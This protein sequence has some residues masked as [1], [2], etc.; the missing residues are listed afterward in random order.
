QAIP[1]AFAE[2]WVQTKST[3]NLVYHMLAGHVSAK[4]LSG[5]IGIAQ[6]ADFTAQM[7]V[8]WFLM[9]LATVSL[10]LGILNLLPIPILDGG[11]LLYYLIELIKGRPLSER[12]LIAG[13]YVGLA[14]LVTLM[15]MAFYNDIMRLIAG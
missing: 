4:N 14:L 9:F 13:Q 1:A 12:V 11:H 2:T 3:A 10:S 7:G 6:A 15:S 8:G 5:V